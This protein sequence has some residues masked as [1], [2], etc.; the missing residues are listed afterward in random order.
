VPVPVDVRYVVLPNTVNPRVLARVRW[1]DVAQAI[2][3]DH[4]EWQDDPVLFDLPFDLMQGVSVAQAAKIA[5]RW[6]AHLPLDT[7]ARGLGQLSAFVPLTNGDESFAA[8]SQP[9]E[10]V[11]RRRHTRFTLRGRAQLAQ[12]PRTIRADLLDVGPGGFRCAVDDAAG[13]VIGTHLDPSLLLQLDQST[14]TSPGVAGTV[15][16]CRREGSVTYLGVAFD[17]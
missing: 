15:V 7:T 17:G 4:P 11:D 16:W 13:T 14:W 10:V 9:Q 8:R 1:P 12:G 6:G 3:A 2:T 5:A